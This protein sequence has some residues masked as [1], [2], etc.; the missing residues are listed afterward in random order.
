MIDTDFVDYLL[1]NWNRKYMIRAKRDV[2]KFSVVIYGGK[3]GAE[4]CS[5][6][7]KK[8]ETQA[9]K[10]VDNAIAEIEK[11]V[12]DVDHPDDALN[13]LLELF[14]AFCSYQ[15]VGQ[16]EQSKQNGKELTIRSSFN[17][18]GLL[19]FWRSE[20]KKIF[21]NIE[22]TS[23]DTRGFGW[24][25]SCFTTIPKVSESC[26]FRLE[27]NGQW[28][29]QYRGSESIFLT[30][31]KG[32]HYIHY[33][34]SKAGKSIHVSEL[35]WAYE[36]P[37][38]DR[39][40]NVYQK[41]GKGSLHELK[42][43]F[44]DGGIDAFDDRTKERYQK[45]LASLESDI[46]EAEAMG[47]NEKA[48]MHRCEKDKVFKQLKAAIGLGGKIRS[49]GSKKATLRSG[50]QKNIKRQLDRMK[51]CNS[52]LWQHLAASIKTGFLCSY[53]PAELPSWDLDL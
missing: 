38:I 22:I 10:D 35:V 53:N 19:R 48:E 9:E 32:L 24:T 2:N 15:M 41:S 13:V 45:R 18:R 51:T 23:R 44:I 4:I 25:P 33:L 8:L 12:S 11:S 14:L 6:D 40:A 17:L 43:A 31:Q 52:P 30:N 21:E 46:E 26:I 37:F 5:I 39:V 29:L 27:E 16:D 34:I 7:N 47:N 36:K 28:R 49:I 3:G 20:R 42:V 50:V 1:H